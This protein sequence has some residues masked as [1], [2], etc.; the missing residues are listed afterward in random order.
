M[1]QSGDVLAHFKGISIFWKMPHI[2]LYVRKK[3]QYTV[4]VKYATTT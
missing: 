2:T 3:R 1:Y 4:L